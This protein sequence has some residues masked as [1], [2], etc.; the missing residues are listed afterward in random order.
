MARSMVSNGPKTEVE[1]RL[2]QEY[3]GK[4][5]TSAAFAARSGY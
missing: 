2:I 1:P 3:F 5:A 4:Q